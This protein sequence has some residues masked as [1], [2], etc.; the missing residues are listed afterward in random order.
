MG[1]K[2]F[3]P[4]F[5]NSYNHATVV[6]M[7]T[8]SC[9]KWVNVDSDVFAFAQAILITSGAMTGLLLTVYSTTQDNIRHT[10]IRQK[11]LLPSI[12]MN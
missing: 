12:Y 4:S 10:C 3:E 11:T 8:I 1:D 6:D 2:R 5:V 7:R 9:Y